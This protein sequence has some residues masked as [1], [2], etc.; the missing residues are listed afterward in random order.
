MLNAL[1]LTE[2]FPVHRFIERTGLAIT[3]I[4]PALREAEQRGLIARD[5]ER[6]APTPLGQRFL[7]DL[8]ALFL[9]E[10]DA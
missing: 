5:H 8:Q 6:I 2:G 4:E 1:R 9:N 10:R 3:A 7:N